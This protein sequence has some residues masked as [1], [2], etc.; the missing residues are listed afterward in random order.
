[1]LSRTLRVVGVLILLVGLAVAWFLPNAYYGPCSVI[2]EFH[3]G[4]H[5]RT[6]L[7][8]LIATVSLAVA[9]GLWATT[10]KRPDSN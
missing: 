5:P 2:T 4:Y 8:L 10:S 1:M 6:E 7:S 3:C 9:V